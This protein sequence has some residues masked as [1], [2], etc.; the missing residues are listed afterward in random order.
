MLRNREFTAST[1]DLSHDRNACSLGQQLLHS[2][3]DRL[4]SL[5]QSGRSWC[6]RLMPIALRSPARPSRWPRVSVL[7]CGSA[8]EHSP[9][10]Q[11]P[12]WLIES[13]GDQSRLTWYC[14]TG[15]SLGSFREPAD[16]QH[17]WLSRDEKQI[18]VEKTDATTSRRHHLDTR[19]GARGYDAAPHDADRR[20]STDC[21]LTA[22]IWSSTRTGWAELICTRCVPMAR[23]IRQSFSVLLNV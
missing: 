22:G 3:P 21:P 9:R 18:V 12:R 16:D 23:A 19:P 8:M 6:I 13:S 10:C 14:R 17:P 4:L 7:M 2:L 11:T 5:K 15:R 1:L 20:T